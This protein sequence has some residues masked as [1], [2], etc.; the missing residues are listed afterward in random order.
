ML[1]FGT[2]ITSVSRNQLYKLIYEMMQEE[3]IGRLLFTVRYLH[4]PNYVEL[5]TINKDV[6][7]ILAKLTSD[8]FQSSRMIT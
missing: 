4:C 1:R 5:Q 7:H 3:N 8:M 2:I 6:I